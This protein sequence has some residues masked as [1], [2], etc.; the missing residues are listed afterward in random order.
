[1]ADKI[2]SHGHEVMVHTADGERYSLSYN[3]INQR[4]AAK[5][6]FEQQVNDALAGE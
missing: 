4:W 3:M 1:M 6:R 5:A 2:I